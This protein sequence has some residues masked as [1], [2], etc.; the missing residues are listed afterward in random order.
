M[1]WDSLA[2]FNG[3]SKPMSHTLAHAASDAYLDLEHNSHLGS[4]WGCEVSHHEVGGT[5]FKVFRG[6]STIVS[7]RGTE[8]DSIEDWVSDLKAWKEDF[9]GGEAHGGFVDAYDS[10]ADQVRDI[11]ARS[12][13]ESK[14]VLITGHS[15]GGGIANLAML[16]LTKTGHSARRCYTFGSP[17]VLGWGLAQVA[18]NE[19][20]GRMFRVVNRNDIVP[21]IPT[22]VRFQHVG[23]LGYINR[24]N[25]IQINPA[26]GYV[27]YDRILGYRANMLRSHSMKHYIKGTGN[28]H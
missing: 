7:F 16:D 2:R 27:T 17:R 3:F 1:D 12:I 22:M 8:P 14:S 9:H 18:K 10:V 23:T 24:F 25:S 19:L 11:A 6:P 5:Q 21:R 28:V 4:K 26:F 15:L 20:N 13:D